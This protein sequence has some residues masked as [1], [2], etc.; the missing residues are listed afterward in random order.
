MRFWICAV[1]LFL[2]LSALALAMVDPF[3]GVEAR[4]RACKERNIEA[5]KWVPKHDDG[6]VFPKVKVDEALK[7]MSSIEFP[8]KEKIDAAAEAFKNDPAAVFPKYVGLVVSDCM[9]LQMFL[10]KGLINTAVGLKPADRSLREKIASALKSIFQQ[11]KYPT[12]ISATMEGSMINYGIERG[13]WAKTKQGNVINYRAELK[14]ETKEANE[15][16]RL[17]WERLNKRMRGLNE[18]KATELL[19]KDQDFNRV[20]P[21]ILKEMERAQVYQERLRKIAEGL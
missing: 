7:M 3:E 18:A 6:Y 12:Y 15:Q 10:E 14:A 19:R 13:L 8:T 16:T 1:S 20:A 17:A 4:N 11:T 2:G 9:G 21:S 5:S